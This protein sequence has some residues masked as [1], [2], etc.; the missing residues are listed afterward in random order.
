MSLPRTKLDQENRL[1]SR[2]LSSF[3]SGIGRSPAGM[4]RARL[5]SRWRRHLRASG[6]TSIGKSSGPVYRLI[7]YIQEEH[8]EICSDGIAD[9][10]ISGQLRSVVRALWL[11]HLL[12]GNTSLQG[13]TTVRRHYSAGD[14]RNVASTAVE[15]LSDADSYA[16]LLQYG[17]HLSARWLENHTSAHKCAG[18]LAWFATL[19]TPQK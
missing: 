14:I 16:W 18:Y 4:D 5:V 10:Q 9:D 7:P 2:F 17:E 8:P 13:W 15:A 12:S 1:V 11:C 3:E 19:P 6:V